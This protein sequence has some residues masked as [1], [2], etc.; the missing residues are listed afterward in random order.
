M[1]ARDL[2][3][4]ARAS[5]WRWL[6]VAGTVAAAGAHVPVIGPHLDEAPYMGVAFVMLTLACL[7]IAGAALVRDSDLVYGLAELTC[8]LAI[9]GYVVT[10]LVAF[11]HLADD[12]GDWLEPLGI[13]SVLAE[14]VVIGAAIAGYIVTR[15]VAFPHL[16]D[17]VGDW[18]E[19]LGIASVLAETVVIGAA[20]AAL[21]A[22]PAERRPATGLPSAGD[23][24]WSPQRR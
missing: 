4:T 12:V 9:A 10:R 2:V 6:V 24:L 15:L 22:L 3:F 16:A 17:D 7:V 11:P 23:R 5:G 1:G 18:L 19:P 21:C 13:A 20:I 14:T 8:G